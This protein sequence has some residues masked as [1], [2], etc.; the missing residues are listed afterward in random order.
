MQQKSLGS[1]GL[2]TCLPLKFFILVINKEILVPT[3][4]ILVKRARDNSVSQETQ[5]IIYT[6]DL[7]VLSKKYIK[8]GF[9][10]VILAKRCDIFLKKATFYFIFFSN[11]DIDIDMIEKEI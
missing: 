6:L 4:N 8:T 10:S 1:G 11:V 3:D 5:L 7:L 2:Q 9:F